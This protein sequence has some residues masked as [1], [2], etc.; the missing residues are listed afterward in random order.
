MPTERDIGVLVGLLIGEGSFTGDG[1]RPQV[2]LRMHVRHRA[3]FD[4]LMAT[5]PG[6]RL[7]GPYHHGGRHYLQWMATGRFLREELTPLLRAHITPALDAHAH[8]R[9]AEM[10]TTYRLDPEGPPGP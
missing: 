10:C 4:W 5:F 2:T 6:G 1:R 3:L 8:S 9:L 7:Y